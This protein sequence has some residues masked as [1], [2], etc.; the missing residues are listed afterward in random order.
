M[1]DGKLAEG[2]GDGGTLAGVNWTP[3]SATVSEA[4]IVSVLPN[5]AR[6]AGPGTTRDGSTGGDPARLR[7]LSFHGFSWREGS[8]RPCSLRASSEKSATALSDAVPTTPRSAAAEQ[9]KMKN[10]KWRSSARQTR[11][12]NLNLEF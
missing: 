10:E 1:I 12:L 5:T 4:E 8:A 11:T 7:S 6:V 9:F 2:A 3:P